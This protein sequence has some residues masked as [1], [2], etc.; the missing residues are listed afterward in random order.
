MQQRTREHTIIHTFSLIAAGVG[1][2]M[3]AL[4]GSDAPVLSTIQAAL[5][6]ALADLHGVAM[7]HTTAAE[8]A[9]TMSATMTGRRLSMVLRLALPAL[10]VA[11]NAVTA[12]AITESVGWAAATWFRQE[13]P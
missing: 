9:L 6:L 7:S 11:V 2:G 5:I 13:Q 3:S 12:A 1:G 4:P 8:L 10:G